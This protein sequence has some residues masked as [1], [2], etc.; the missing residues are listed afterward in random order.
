MLRWYWPESGVRLFRLIG[1]GGVVDVVFPVC[2]MLMFELFRATCSV[3]EK[4][5]WAG[6][7]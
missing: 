1:G 6:G 7:L 4:L 3:I 2:G 5:L